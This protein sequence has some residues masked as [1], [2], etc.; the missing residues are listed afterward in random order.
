MPKFDLQGAIKAG[1]TYKEA[2]EFLKTQGVDFDLQGAMNSGGNIKDIEV[3]LNERLNTPVKKKDDTTPISKSGTNATSQSTSPSPL[4]SQQKVEPKP[5]PKQTPPN[6]VNTLPSF[7][8]QPQQVNAKGISQIGSNIA[9][10]TG[11]KT[12]QVSVQ[13]QKAVKEFLGTPTKVTEQKTVPINQIPSIV[14]PITDDKGN[15]LTQA[16]VD[17]T[18]TKVKEQGKLQYDMQNNITAQAERDKQNITTYNGSQ[19]EIQNKAKKLGDT[20][21]NGILKVGDVLNVDKSIRGYLSELD[22]KI[23]D[24]NKA[25]DNINKQRDILFKNGTTTTELDKKIANYEKE[26][27]RLLVDRNSDLDR[28]ILE[29]QQKIKNGYDE[30]EVSPTD[31]YIGAGYQDKIKQ[32][33]PLKDADILNLKKEI[34]VLKQ[35]KGAFLDDNNI[36]AVQ[37]TYNSVKNVIGQ[38]E[39][40]NIIPKDAKPTQKMKALYIIKYNQLE[41]L[42]KKSQEDGSPFVTSTDSPIREFVGDILGATQPLNVAKKLFSGD[43]NIY[44]AGNKNP[45]RQRLVNDETTK[46]IQKLERELKTL[47]PIVAINRDAINKKAG[48]FETTAKTFVDK[49][50]ATTT[51]SNPSQNKASV[52][53]DA[54]NTAGVTLKDEQTKTLEKIQ[55]DNGVTAE[56]LGAGFGNT[57]AFM[58]EFG[59]TN[60][61]IG[62]VVGSLGSGLSKLVGAG[63]TAKYKSIVG[64]GN[65]ILKDTKIGRLLVGMS[66]DVIK[67]SSAGAINKQ[68]SEEVNASQ[69]ASGYLGGKLGEK[70]VNIASKLFGNQTTKLL[71]VLGNTFGKGLFETTEEITQDFDSK[72]KDLTGKN[73]FT[74]AI[75]LF[76]N[77]EKGKEFISSVKSQYGDADNNVMLLIS[78]FGMALAF[79]GTKFAK[80]F[81]TKAEQDYNKLSPQ[82]KAVADKILNDL[83]AEQS[84]AEQKV[85]TSIANET[86]KTEDEVKATIQGDVPTN[87]PLEV[88]PQPIVKEDTK[89]GT[90]QAVGETNT[91]TQRKVDIAN[92]IAIN[93]IEK[94]NGEDKDFYNA[95]VEEIDGI[96]AKKIKEKKQLEEARKIFGNEDETTPTEPTNTGQGQDNNGGVQQAQADDKGL[97]GGNKQGILPNQ[98][99]V[100]KNNEELQKEID[101]TKTIIADLETNAKSP[102]HKVV[103]LEEQKQKLVEL[104]KK[105]GDTLTNDIASEQQPTSN[106]SE[107]NKEGSGGVGGDVK[108]TDTQKTLDNAEYQPRSDRNVIIRLPIDKVLKIQ[109]AG[110]NVARGQNGVDSRIDRIKEFLKGKPKK[111]EASLLNINKDNSLGI[112]GRHRLEAAKEM[113]ATHSM[114]EIKKSDEQ[115]LRDLLNEPVEQPLPTQEVKTNDLPTTSNKSD[116]ESQKATTKSGREEIF[117]KEQ[118]LKETTKAETTSNISNQSEIEAKKAEI[119]KRRQEELSGIVQGQPIELYDENGKLIHTTDKSTAINAKYDAELKALEQSLKETTKAETTNTAS[120]VGVEEGSVGVVGDSGSIK[121]IKQLESENKTTLPKVPAKNVFS[122]DVENLTKEQ[123]G[124]ADNFIGTEKENELPIETISIKDIVPTQKNLTIPNLEEVSKIKYG[125]KINEPIIL[126]KK[127][128]KYYVVDGHHRIANEILKGNTN[129]EAKVYNEQSLKETPETKNYDYNEKE[130]EVQALERLSKGLENLTDTERKI[131]IE[132]RAKLHDDSYKSKFDSIMVAENKTLPRYD[133]FAGQTAKA[134]EKFINRNEEQVKND[135]T[136][137]APTFENGA[138]IDENGNALNENE[139]VELKEKVKALRKDGNLDEIAKI[140][141]APKQYYDNLK[142]NT[143]LDKNNTDGEQRADT[144]GETETQTTS[145]TTGD[146]SIQQDTTT[147]ES[148]KGGKGSRNTKRVG[149]RTPKAD[150]KIKN[151]DYLKALSYNPN[152]AEEMV[153]QSFIGGLKIKPKIIEKLFKNSLGEKKARIQLLSKNGADTIS[154]IAHSLWQNQVEFFGYEKF[155]SQEIEN[156][157]ESVI[158]GFNTQRKMVDDLNSYLKTE[159]EIEDESRAEEEEY[160][161]KISNIEQ[162]TDSDIDQSI[163]YYE[164]LTDADIKEIEIGKEEVLKQQIEEFLNEQE[165]LNNENNLI[166]E[167]DFLNKKVIDLENELKKKLNKLDENLNETQVNLFGNNKTQS[168][169]ND[170]AEQQNIIDNLKKEIEVQKENLK[171]AQQQLDVIKNNKNQQLLFSKTD[172]TNKFTEI[173]KKRFDKLIKTLQKAFPKTK[174]FTDKEIFTEKL[175]KYNNKIDLTSK[176]GNIYG[177]KFPDGSIYI[178]TENGFNANTPMHEFGHLLEDLLPVEFKKGIELLKN[179]AEGRKLIEKIRNS[180]AYKGNTKEQI[181]AEALVTAL[182]NKGEIYFNTP[183]YKKFIDWMNDMFA[184][185]SDKIHDATGGFVGTKIEITADTLFDDFMKNTIGDMLGGKEIKGENKKIQKNNDIR[186]QIKDNLQEFVEDRQKDGYTLEETIQWLKDEK[187]KVNEKDFTDSWNYFNESKKTEISKIKDTDSNEV[188]K[189]LYDIGETA[190]KRD[191]FIEQVRDNKSI[192]HLLTNKQINKIFDGKKLSSADKIS[193]K[194]REKLNNKLQEQKDKAKALVDTKNDIGETIN[195]LLEDADFKDKVTPTQL[196]TITK[197]VTKAINSTSYKQIAKLQ[198]YIDKIIKNQ[199][200]VIDIKQARDLQKRISKALIGTKIIAGAKNTLFNLIQLNASEVEDLKEYN[201]KLKKA[202][203][204]ISLTPKIDAKTGQVNNDAIEL[205]YQEILSY[206]KAQYEYAILEKDKLFKDEYGSLYDIAK[207]NVAMELYDINDINKL[208]TEQ[209]YDVIDNIDEDIINGVEENTTIKNTNNDNDTLKTLVALKVQSMPTIAEIEQNGVLLSI[210]EKEIL[211]AIN[212]LDVDKLSKKQLIEVNK[213][214][215]S[216][217]TNYDFSGGNKVKT[218]IEV[219]ENIK[220]INNIKSKVK[221]FRDISAFLRNSGGRL[222][223]FIGLGKQTEYNAGIGL[224]LTDLAKSEKMGAEITRLTRLTSLTKASSQTEMNSNNRKQTIKD[225]LKKNS[226]LTEPLQQARM[227]TYSILMQ[228]KGGNLKD[229]EKALEWAKQRL[230]SNIKN[231]KDS[232]RKNENTVEYN[233]WQ[234]AYDELA[235]AN[236]I[237]EVNDKMKAI[238]PKGITLVNML[239]EMHNGLKDNFKESALLNDNKSSEFDIENYNH[240]KVVNANG[241]NDNEFENKQ[242]GNGIVAKDT[243]SKYSRNENATLS[244]GK[245]ISLNFITQ[246]LQNMQD[247]EFES[248]AKEDINF[249]R[250]LFQSGD[251]Y[252]TLGETNYNILKTHVL[253]MLDTVGFFGSNKSDTDDV[254]KFINKLSS[255]GSI[256]ALAGIGQIFKQSSV[257]VSTFINNPMLTPIAIS[258]YLSNKKAI[259]TLLNKYTIGSRAGLNAGL[260]IKSTEVEQ[261]ANSKEGKILQNIYE[262]AGET[263]DKFRDTVI[264][265]LRFSDVNNAKIGWFTFYLD[266]LQEQGIDIDSIDWETHIE[267]DIAGAFAETKQQKLQGNNANITNSLDVMQMSSS[268]GKRAVFNLL[269]P[270]A[271][272]GQAQKMRMIQNIKNIATGYD[273]KR[274]L[275][276]LTAQITEAVAFQTIGKILL[277]LIFNDAYAFFMREVLDMKRDEPEEEDKDKYKSIGANMFD[278]LAMQGMIPNAISKAIKQKVINKYVKNSK[279]D[280]IFYSDNKDIGT[281]DDIVLSSTLGTVYKSLYDTYNDAKSYATKNRIV[282]TNFVRETENKK[283]I[284]KEVKTVPISEYQKTAIGYVMLIDIAGQFGLSLQEVDKLAREIRT[285]VDYELKKR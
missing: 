221:G 227:Y 176:N 126:I 111:L 273:R 151:K 15:S 207:V 167:V 261:F 51:F 196:A 64:F 284:F 249:L 88:T 161:S 168:L 279:G 197:R 57:G 251:F 29:K 115:A 189:N 282:K 241:V 61:F 41:N 3:F 149:N 6:K 80:L 248:R 97:G 232:K 180:N 96:T 246:Q 208:S 125:T 274:G 47:A 272:F 222:I 277:P 184:K 164:S 259:D 12:K 49:I 133:K 94:L 166:N 224:M 70:I 124:N 257:L 253:A 178:N 4:L 25:I 204:Y 270:F 262:K 86:G 69:G 281:F 143:K 223:N 174:V 91:L 188:V 101:D 181:E 245:K 230:L 239:T 35:R 141:K 98:A 62:G 177:A 33:V 154:G 65:E 242:F 213:L 8:Q 74:G 146:S 139:Y 138:R 79:N 145:N 85:V 107:I 95:F 127:D 225:F 73:F 110:E 21:I 34:E 252:E 100:P 118:S 63:N 81:N 28:Q 263:T 238:L 46:E 42:K 39:K 269:Y 17:N 214:V 254:F 190:D 66:D 175:K 120:N 122:N 237:E 92:K 11:E 40:L 102:F 104:E 129:V 137:K 156:A 53:L 116:I 144:T 159:E 209:L 179:T 210:K 194:L 99:E 89:T 140:N 10:P 55:N 218:I 264:S 280:G 22:L 228:H 13:N 240:I 76:N 247:V 114:F 135:E 78:T 198:E 68:L 136:R 202:L 23:L 171:K 162:Y 48:F 75:E 266:S 83:K 212:K 283:S 215:E 5:T 131:E 16:K 268:Q 203:Q 200:Y 187:V 112:D 128:G 84:T 20:S 157:V 32:K 217:T 243:K 56:N 71:Y 19:I 219:A 103:N 18:F 169:F 117:N 250:E 244:N 182:G 1:G 276:D 152:T 165:V 148:K 77:S 24:N 50:T 87:K 52:I 233:A 173:T 267:N 30:I 206:T 258:K 147:Y 14:Q 113:G 43:K 191:V 158:V 106:Q 45:I 27:A 105:Q 226:T 234:Q 9:M 229:K 255:I 44:L 130:S 193:I 235:D 38:Y 121:T 7:L 72:I 231:L 199:D 216:I 220:E 153:M 205:S 163:Y 271:S 58:V 67:Y 36:Q 108:S 90:A 172:N 2:Q 54:M 26:N 93:G 37:T 142:E 59:L 82:N 285:N 201:E 60:L 150:R 195:Q 211:N 119:E 186:F 31:S 160:L 275:Q 132:R 192:S 260:E 155:D 265:I 109:E 183:M 256:R 185:L 278:D 123:R 134:I 170:K 236:T